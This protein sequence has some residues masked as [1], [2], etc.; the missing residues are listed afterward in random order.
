[1]PVTIEDLASK[2]GVSPSTVSKALNDRADV[3]L[4][5]KER[6]RKTVREL[7]YHP[8]AAARSLRR[9]R[10]DKIGL[11]VN[12]P[13]HMVRDFLAELIPGIA[14]R[15]EQSECH[16][17]LYTAM[18]RNVERLTSLCRSREID[19]IIVAWPPRASETVA[20][21]QLMTEE[22]MPHVFL[23]RRIPHAELSF[24]AADHVG[25]AKALTQHLIDLGHRRIGFERLPEVYETDHDRHS[26]YV[27]ALAAAGIAYQPELV[28]AADSSAADYAARSFRILSALPDPPTAILFFTDP[29]AIRALSLARQ[30]GLRVPQDLSIAGY[31]GILSSGVTEPALTTVWQSAAEMGRLAVESLLLLI[32]GQRGAPIQH[33]LPVKLC[34]RASTGP[35]R[36]G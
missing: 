34:A 2:L 24:V 36:R 10:T 33:T 27:Q 17:I 21:S 8:S 30:A 19:G 23:P 18:A 35:N 3:S 5:T 9:Q 14:A 15:A 7:G 25:G 31:D 26:G 11:V 22:S 29:V 28:V 4:R 6:V 13:I 12:Y 16:L 32:D 1:M 20:L